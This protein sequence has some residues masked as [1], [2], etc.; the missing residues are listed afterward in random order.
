MRDPDVLPQQQRE[1]PDPQESSNPTPWPVLMLIALVFAFG[2][3]Y[4]A[5]SH[6]DTPSSWGDGREA[7]ELVGAKKSAGGKVDGAAT[8]ASMC[9]ACHQATGAGLPGVFPPLAGSE[10]ASGKETTLAAIVLHGV[11]GPITVKGATFNGAMPA[12]K[13]Q[14]NDQ[15]IAAVLTHIRSQWGNASPA[16]TAETVAA[17]REAQKARTASFAGEKELAA[18]P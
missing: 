9:A 1:N 14:L 3:V 18:L 5:N 11:T 2:V 13:E 6:L 10:W 15:Q 17:V 8:F 4:I 7:A 12:F 16:V